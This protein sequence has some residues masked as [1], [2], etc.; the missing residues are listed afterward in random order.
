MQY[1]FIILLF[2]GILLEGTV[3]TLPLVLV[4]LILYSIC[5]KKIEIF[6]IAFISGMLLDIFLVRA[7][8][9]TSIFYI[10]VLLLISLYE[11]KYEVKSPFF[12]LLIT[13]LVCAL[14]LFIFSRHTV[15]LQTIISMLLSG[16]IF[17]LSRVLFKD[18]GAST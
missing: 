11:R 2:I 6:L 15:V 9:L 17:S 5:I 3:T 18:K 14:Y 1:F 16:G 8:G 12:V 7:I 4:I 10:C 13:G